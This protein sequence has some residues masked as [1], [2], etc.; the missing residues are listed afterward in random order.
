MG[1]RL[2]LNSFYFVKKKPIE[3]WLQIAL[4]INKKPAVIYTAK[5]CN[6]YNEAHGKKEETPNY[7]RIYDRLILI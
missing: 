2:D 7:C 4:Q 3:E 5:I 1:P 6:R